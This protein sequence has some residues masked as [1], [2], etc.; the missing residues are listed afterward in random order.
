MLLCVL[1]AQVHLNICSPDARSKASCKL[2][3]WQSR[4]I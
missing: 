2:F 1:L 3:K 4:V